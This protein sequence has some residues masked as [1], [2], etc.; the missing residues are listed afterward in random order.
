M[1]NEISIII[2]SINPATPDPNVN[3]EV[4]FDVKHNADDEIIGADQSL[5]GQASNNDL[6]NRIKRHAKVLY[7]EYESQKVWLGY[8]LPKTFQI[9]A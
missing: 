3:R 5:Q 6:F 4:T 8:S 2:K 9:D 1:A 7:Q